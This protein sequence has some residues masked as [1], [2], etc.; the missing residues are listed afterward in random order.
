MRPLPRYALAAICMLTAGCYTYRPVGPS[1]LTVDMTV[2][3]ELAENT[4]YPRLEGKVIQVTPSTL[5]VLPETR[6]GQDGA[7]REVRI[8]GIRAISRREL[9]TGRTALLIGAGFGAAI[10]T[11]LIVEGTPGDTRGPGGG[12][13]FNVLGLAR[14]LFP[15]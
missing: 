12:G 13:D 1:D 8:D 3:L 15:R 4:S 2:R 7:P 14:A 9:H 6:P 5:S 11:L 10:A